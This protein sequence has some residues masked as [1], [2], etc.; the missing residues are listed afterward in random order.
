MNTP[1]ADIIEMAREKACACRVLLQ[2]ELVVGTRLPENTLFYTNA[3]YEEDWLL[4]QS[5]SRM[6]IC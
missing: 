1:P 3:K 4:A 6:D 2:R 5:A